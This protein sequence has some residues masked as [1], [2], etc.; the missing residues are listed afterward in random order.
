MLR[1]VPV[2]GSRVCHPKMCYFELIKKQ[3]IKKQQTRK[4][5]GEKKR[6]K[7]PFWKGHLHLPRKSPFVN[8]SLSVPGRE[9]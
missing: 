4:A 2:K 5:L 1:T 7:L 9:G 6:E 8:A 3:P